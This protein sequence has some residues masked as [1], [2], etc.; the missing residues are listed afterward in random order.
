MEPANIIVTLIDTLDSLV[1]VKPFL[2]MIV[3]TKIKNCSLFDFLGHNES[4]KKNHEMVL[5]T[6]MIC[7]FCS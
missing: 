4:E 7:G 2:V 6:S 1:V 3:I 5:A